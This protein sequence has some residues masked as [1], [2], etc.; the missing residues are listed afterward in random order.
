MRQHGKINDVNF[1]YADNVAVRCP[2]C[3]SRVWNHTCRQTIVR[4]RPARMRL[5]DPRWRDLQRECIGA[6]ASVRWHAPDG[7]QR[8]AWGWVV[9]SAAAGWPQPQD[10]ARRHERVADGCRSHNPR[11]RHE[12]PLRTGRHRGWGY[13]RLMEAAPLARRKTLRK[14]TSET[15]VFAVHKLLHMQM[16]NVDI[17][18][19]SNQFIDTTR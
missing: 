16:F 12:L 2:G 6:S 19:R 17:S 8:R 4:H 13:R 10:E 9:T 1:C 18:L 7:L 14:Q 15:I 3:P 11:T 5:D